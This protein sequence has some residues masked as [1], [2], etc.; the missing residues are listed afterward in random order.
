M[1]DTDILIIGGGLSGLY[2]AYLLSRKKISFTLLEARSRMG[3][4]ILSTQHNGYFS[5]MGP[6]W[7]WPEINPKFVQ[8]VQF[9]GLDGYRQ[10]ENGLGRFQYFDGSVASVRRYGSM[11]ASWRI[12]GGMTSLIT[13]LLEYVPEKA[14]RFQHPVCEITKEASG[15][16]VSVGELEKD[17]QCQFKAQK[18]ILAIPPRLAA[19]TILFTPDLSFH[20][21][22]AMLGT[23]TW[24]AGQ[25][26]FCALYNDPFW[27]QQGFSG[28]AFSQKGP[29]GE[30]HD[31]SFDKSQGP[32][33]STGFVN[34]PAAQRNHEQELITEI[35]FQL[36]TI[37]G[38]PADQ[39]VSCYYQDWAREPYTATSFDQPPM[40]E[41]PDYH[42]PAG[43]TTLWDGVIHFAGT[44]TADQYGG[45]LEGALSSAQRA[46]MNLSQI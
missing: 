21:T 7:Y 11:P 4:R 26:K 24:M 17:I 15:A 6:S 22:Q 20:L 10:F 43:R 42:P 31:G 18:I 16:L 1:E 2:A 23:P 34:I 25:A 5:D 44:E 14:I 45:Y 37:Y 33:G 19:A 30:I 35:L 8:L 28:Q 41:H 29:L 9:F 12:S 38:R 36:K 27:R 46:V 3:G 32:Y 39:P 40:R 13:N